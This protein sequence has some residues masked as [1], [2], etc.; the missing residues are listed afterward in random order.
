MF[1]NMV[2]NFLLVLGHINYKKTAVCKGRGKGS[3]KPNGLDC[4]QVATIP[5]PKKTVVNRKKQ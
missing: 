2:F 5:G 3:N 1:R 4:S